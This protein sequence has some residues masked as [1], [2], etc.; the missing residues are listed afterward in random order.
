[1][2]PNDREVLTRAFGPGIFET[3]GSREVMLMSAECSVHEGMHLAEENI[4]L[5]VVKDGKPLPPG[6]SGDVAV[7]D[8]HNYGFPF[9][10]YLNGDMARMHDATPCP[11]GRGLRR[12]QGVDGR[13]ADTLTDKEGRPVPGLLFHVLFGDARKEAV[14]QFQVVQKKDLSVTFK[15][16]RG[17]GWDESIA[18]A[19][20][21]RAQE[22]L[23]G[24]PVKLE[25]CTE[26]PPLPNGKRKTVLVE[27]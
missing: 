10:R 6:E 1:M 7:T 21:E 23:H 3:Y 15:V 13:R 8:L 14:S 27:R 17:P 16:V 4:L 22:Y 12:L 9:I 11:C 20:Q 5:E 2:L 18:R 19:I 26:I 25:E 24:R